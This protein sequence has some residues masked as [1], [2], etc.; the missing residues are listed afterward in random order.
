MKD[1]SSQAKRVLFA[2]LCS[3]NDV[4]SVLSFL[5][6]EDASSEN[7]RSILTYLPEESVQKVLQSPFAPPVL[8]L[9]NWVGHTGIGVENLILLLPRLVH[10]DV[11]TLLIE[12]KNFLL[13]NELFP[14]M[15]L[16]ACSLVLSHPHIQSV[17]KKYN[18]GVENIKKF[19]RLEEQRKKMSETFGLDS[20]KP[21]HH[22][23]SRL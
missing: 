3:G 9:E 11:A 17:L 18:K 15:N 6:N 12:S 8:P 7:Y 16:E 2:Q 14:H 13:I 10:T 23:A 1:L 19:Q 5:E 21:K 20:R 4:P 22:E